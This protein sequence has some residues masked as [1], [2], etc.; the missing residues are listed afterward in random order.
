MSAATLSRPRGAPPTEP[1]PTV[2]H[3]ADTTSL[4]RVRIVV[5]LVGF[6]VVGAAASGIFDATVWTLVLAPLA[7]ST[8]ALLLVRRHGAI[9]LA[10]AIGAI[11]ASIVL[12][13]VAA[14]G[15]LSD[16]GGALTSGIQG[17][18]S[19][20]W[21]SP[22]RPELVGT[23]A[24]VIAT[25]TAISDEL[26]RHRRFHLLPLLPLLAAYVGVIALSSPLGVRWTWLVLLTA[27]ATCFALLRNDVALH[28]R[29]VLLRGER[30]LIP[31]LAIAVGMTVLIAIPLNLN[32]RAD[33]RRNDP[34]RQTAPLLDPIEATLALRNLDPPIDLHIVTPQPG[35]TLPT[36]WRTAALANY[37]GRRWTPN[38]TVRPIGTTLGPATGPIV[39]ADI[40]FLDASLLLV[41]LPGV[42]VSVDAPVET[43][44][45]RTIVRLLDR[46]DSPV[47]VVANAA[48]TAA[49]AI[50]LGVAPRLVDESASGLTTLAVGLAGDGSPTE[51]LTKL[52]STM[53]NDFVLDSKVQGGGL[54]QALIERFLR[55]TQRGTR[56]QFAT[57]FVLLARAIGVEARVATGFV[58]DG[59]AAGGV[60]AAS[61]PGE[62]L[63]LSSA[64]ASIWPEVRLTDGRW[65]AYDPVPAQEATDGTP[66]PPEPQVQSPAAP[67]PPIAPPPEPDNQTNETDT[68]TE[69]NTQDA[70]STVVTWT[71]RGAA[72]V[73]VV[74]LPFLIAAAIILAIKHRRR[75]RRL[76]A[77]EPVD[78]IRGAWASATDALVDG[79]LDIERSH[80]DAEISA[81]GEPMVAD[82]SRELRRL[83]ALSSEATYGTPQHP[84]LLAEDAATCLE[85]IEASMAGTRTRW[86]RVRWRLSLRSLRPAT[87]SPVAT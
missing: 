5:L 77:D 33:P 62:P 29:L 21:P 9:R 7:P 80:T 16:I 73:F 11:L 8:A 51:R 68:T 23:I 49:D 86:Q 15:S 84:D 42:P 12:A 36:R 75:R 47:S 48:P 56:E 39:S 83:A 20:D 60:T 2:E 3:G 72:G 31:L 17:L 4:T 52:E 38:L 79:G 63:V 53:R 24:A 13:V 55:D 82:A 22:V 76:D 59:S 65:L 26:V 54:Q 45:D 81:R 74:S 18:L 69:Q 30:R 57:A 61:A 34:A 66:P 10:G 1:A 41:P 28:D 44:A 35:E 6:S 78:R 19:T 43:D 25:S 50:E 32:T 64:D 40:S 70:L 14:S 58:A 37:D 85:R 87:R 27:V 67:Q 46:P 71:A